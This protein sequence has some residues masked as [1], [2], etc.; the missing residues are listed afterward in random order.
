MKFGIVIL[1]YM[2]YKDTIELIDSIENQTLKNIPV[3]IID[4]FSNNDSVREISNRICNLP[5]Y[6]LIS[7]D[8]NLGFAKGNNIGI[9]YLNNTL[10]IFNVLL[11]NNDLIFFEED[12]LQKISE[13]K[14]DSNIGALGT[15]IIGSDKLNQNPKNWK[16]DKE[17]IK[18]NIFN[19]ENQKKYSYTNLKKYLLNSNLGKF[20]W[21]IKTKKNDK[22]QKRT[23]GL[24]TEQEILHGA[25]ILLTQNYFKVY[26][27][28]YPETFLYGEEIILNIFLNKANLKKQYLSDISVYHKEDQ[29]SG[30]S[31][32]NNFK[33]MEKY[34]N[35]SNHIILK[36][37]DLTINEIK[38]LFYEKG[39]Y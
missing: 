32:S 38:E 16:Y 15:K 23:S 19:Y 14:L 25:C 24:L 5:N 10:N 27:G 28:I 30:I 7:T 21:K 4:N 35:D 33:I 22:I 29:S 11:C 37:Y 36:I 3:I 1:N 20:I 17:S 39:L 9:E 8:K 34:H 2:N 18:K 12:Y 26:P 31:F 6:K 13:L